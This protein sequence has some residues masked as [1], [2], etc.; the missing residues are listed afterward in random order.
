MTE[1]AVYR[2]YDSHDKLLYVGLASCPFVRSKS[3]KANSAWYRDVRFMEVEWHPD[4]ATAAHAERLA[5]DRERP[6]YNKSLQH[7][8]RQV[9]TTV[10]PAKE[11]KVYYNCGPNLPPKFGPCERGNTYMIGLP[12]ME[13]QDVPPN[14]AFACDLASIRLAITCCRE[15]DVL[16]VDNRIAV[17]DGILSGAKSDGVYVVIV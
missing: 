12:D 6:Q 4:R 14:R 13:M 7:V 16:Y 11:S 3:H 15:G 10:F 5:I 17:P 9:A 1:A 8:Q 2:F